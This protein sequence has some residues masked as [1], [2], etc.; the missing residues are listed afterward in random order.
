MTIANMDAGLQALSTDTYIELFELDTSPLFIINGIQQ[1]G[2]VVYR[3]TSGIIDLRTQGIM[4]VGATQTATVV[5]LDRLLNLIEGRTY[6][7][8]VQTNP[9]VKPTPIAVSSWGT[10]TVPG[11]GGGPALTVT[12]LTLALSLPAVPAVGMPYVFLGTNPVTFQGN[13]YTP[14][15]I[16]MTGVEWSGQGKLP[17]PT[18]RVSNIGG[19]AAGLVIAYGDMLG[20]TVTRLRTL[21]EF[22]DDGSA[23]DPTS[24]AEPDIY[25]L[26]RKS[27]Q[28][29]AAVEWEC[30]ASLDQQGLKIPRRVMIRDTC[31]NIY[32]QLV[33]DPTTGAQSFVYGTCPYSGTAYFT[34]T[35]A[36]TSDPTQDVC[37][38]LMSGCL[39]RFGQTT[40][41]PF[42]GFPGLSV[43]SQ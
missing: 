35:D 16:E 39:A 8:A 43:T 13:T 4:P 30:T 20:A 29:K 19:L 23:A 11:P 3:W 25:T 33:T 1:P 31:D 15:P 5:T 28:T 12:Q 26:D 37:S 21:R 34:N 10:A 41:L 42:G 2:G 32:R 38:L 36:S 7:L 14:M 22:L 24:Y 18:L 27:S 9:D 6:Q 40:P 17:R